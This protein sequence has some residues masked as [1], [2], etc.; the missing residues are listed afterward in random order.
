MS[1][2]NSKALRNLFD[3]AVST[4]LISRQSST[5]LSG[6][7]G[8]VVVAGA[9]G[10][11]IEDIEAS[12]VM[13]VT[14]LLDASSSI[15]SRGL[16]KAV[17]EGYNQ[18]LDTF[19]LSR[20]RDSIL[21]AL[22]TFNDSRSVL[23]SYVPVSE[24]ASLNR[25]NYRPAGCT[26]LYDTWCEALAAN[27]AYAQRLRESGTP[28]KSLMVVITDGEDVGSQRSPSDCAALSRDLL[29]TEQ[30][31]LAFVGVGSDVD[32]RSVAQSMGVPE[33]CIEVQS[34]ATPQGLRDLFQMVS[35]SAIKVSQS[36]VGPGPNTGFFH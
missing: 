27:V 20:E 24:A 35:Q 9:A 11:D 31:V 17:R 25:R 32:F 2:K 12:D 18:L 33:R 3:D 21:M 19:A 13:L 34:Q 23:H 36:R 10:R 22:W 1:S 26:A 8:P 16:G 6:N 4:G 15:A 29:A 28:C 30:F 5:L 7:L 14:V